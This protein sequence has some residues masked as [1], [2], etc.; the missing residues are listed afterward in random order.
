M[1][2]NSRE[3]EVLEKLHLICGESVD[4]CRSVLE[5]LSIVHILNFIDGTETVVPF[6][7]SV[8]IDHLGD[9]SLSGKLLKAKLGF[10]I[11]P[12][13]ILTKNIGQIVDGIE[14]DI[15]K[16]FKKKIRSSMEEIIEQ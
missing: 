14:S 5:A 12:S 1:K 9:E 2:L 11:E 4:V 6:F 7:G 3:K 15:E 13:L 8:K 10:K 16:L